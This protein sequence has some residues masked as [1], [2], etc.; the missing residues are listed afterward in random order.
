MCGIA[1]IVNF[2]EEADIKRIKSMCD[3]MQ[4]R[5]PDAEGIYIKDNIALG[6][7]RLSVIDIESGNQPMFSDD[8]NIV[9]VFN[10]EIYNFKK[11][12]N[13]LESLSQKFSTKSDTEV[14]IKGYE[15][16][17]LEGLLEKIEGMY[18]FAL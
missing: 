12:R 11:L 2:K 1:G 6:H 13:E 9:I 18:A 14:I 15:V 8:G 4:R 7:R 5:G 3:C 17:R 10:G 16:F